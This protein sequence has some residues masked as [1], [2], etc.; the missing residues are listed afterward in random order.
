MSEGI[1]ATVAFPGDVPCPVVEAAAAA[2]AVIES[3]WSSVSSGSRPS[4][5]EF[6]IE[7]Q[8][9]PSI[10]A[11][12]H[13]LSLGHRHLYR[14]EHGPDVACPCTVLGEFGCAVQRYLAR[15]DS[16][17]LVFNAARYEELRDVV[18][19]LRERFPGLDV[20]R[21]VRASE[22][23][24]TDPGVFVDRG[25]LTDRQLEVLETAF[26]MGYFERPR[27]ANAERVAAALDIA[28]S[29]FAEH[30]AAAQSKL[31]EDVLEDRPGRGP[32][33]DG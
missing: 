24:P 27:G 3:V 4:V 30:L 17:Q 22:E 21:L 19:A 28:P 29:T 2:D 18:G 14:V 20:R 12:E 5:S 26:E 33:R 15:A 32:S 13:V 25:R 31:L 8:A 1:R 9:P 7:G 10:P 23:A 11:A 6:L 16:L